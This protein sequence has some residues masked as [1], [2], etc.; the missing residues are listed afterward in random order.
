MQFLKILT[1]VL[2]ATIVAASVPSTALAQGANDSVLTEMAQAFRKGDRKKLAQLLP[3]ARGHVLEPWAAYWELKARL[4]EASPQE[5]DAFLQRYAGT[6]QEDRLRND[7]LLQLGKRREW[8]A[9]AAHHP[10]FRMSD[11]REVRC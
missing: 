8:E 4:D 5:V 6:Y 1:P 10:L 7:W 3:Q 11:D 9:F 2:V